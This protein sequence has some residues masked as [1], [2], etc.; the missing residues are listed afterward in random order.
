MSNLAMTDYIKYRQFKNKYGLDHQT[1]IALLSGI[2]SIGGASGQMQ[3]FKE[4]KFKIKSYN[5]AIENA[6]RISMIE[7]YFDGYKQTKFIGAILIILKNPNFSFT[8]FL[9]KLKQQPMSL[10]KCAQIEQYKT[11]IEDIYNYRRREKVNLRF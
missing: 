6:E 9:Q 2:S 10:M 5:E 1:C 8:E 4:G 3:Q 7:P 11:L